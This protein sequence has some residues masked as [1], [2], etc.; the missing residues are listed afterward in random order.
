MKKNQPIFTGSSDSLLVYL[1][2]FIIRSKSNQ[3]KKILAGYDN[4]QTYQTA[5]VES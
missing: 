1:G 2:F 3:A 5:L 4:K